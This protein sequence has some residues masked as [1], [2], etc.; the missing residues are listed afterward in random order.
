VAANVCVATAC[1]LYRGMQVQRATSFSYIQ[2][3]QVPSLHHNCSNV[4]MPSLR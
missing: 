1:K 2:G 3:M 4:G